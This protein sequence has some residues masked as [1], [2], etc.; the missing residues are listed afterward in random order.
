MS[1]RKRRSE[2]SEYIVFRMG[3]KTLK[4]AV[5]QLAGKAAGELYSDKLLRK[6]FA[7]SVR[8]Y[9]GF[10]E[11]AS[12]RC[13]VYEKILRELQAC[14]PEVK[15]RNMLRGLSNL[16]RLE[17]KGIGLFAVPKKKRYGSLKLP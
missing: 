7:K 15:W 10:C 9:V 2:L 8:S 3:E 13:D 16:P 4:G 11:S 17:A 1:I 14:K 12:E 5:P 6:Y